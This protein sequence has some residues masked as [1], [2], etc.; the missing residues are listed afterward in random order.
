[1][2]LFPAH[3]VYFPLRIA[4]HATESGI[5]LNEAPLF[6]IQNN[7]AVHRLVIDGAKLVVALLQVLVRLR[8]F[9]STLLYP[10]FQFVVGLLQRVFRP[11]PLGDVFDHADGV[12]RPAR[13]IMH[14]RNRQ[15]SPHRLAIFAKIPFFRAVLRISPRQRR[16]TK[17]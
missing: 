17:G 4:Q 8:Q 14:Q 6:A 9:C 7:D 5:C 10:L 15:L 11:L 16:E 1:M 13:F 3:T 12:Y 2:H